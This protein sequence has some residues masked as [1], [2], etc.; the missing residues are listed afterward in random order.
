MVAA[1]ESA[2]SGMGA[3]VTTLGTAALSVVALIAVFILAKSF[4]TRGAR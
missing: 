1:A 2:I 3:N 4:L